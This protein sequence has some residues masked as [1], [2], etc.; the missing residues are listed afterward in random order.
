MSNRGKCSTY[1]NFRLT[2]DSTQRRV[3]EGKYMAQREVSIFLYVFMFGINTFVS[4]FVNLQ[5]KIV[6]T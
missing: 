1:R 4:P 2:F 5:V 3:T 6:V